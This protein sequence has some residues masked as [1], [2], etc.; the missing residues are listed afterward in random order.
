LPFSFP[1]ARRVRP[2]KVEAARSGSCLRDYHPF[3]SLTVTER[4]PSG[5]PELSLSI[6]LPSVREAFTPFPWICGFY[7]MILIFF[8]SPPRLH[9][10]PTLNLLSS[11]FVRT[12]F[13][14]KSIPYFTSLFCSL[15]PLKTFQE[16]G[17][18]PQAIF[19]VGWALIARLSILKRAVCWILRPHYSLFAGNLSGRTSHLTV[20]PAPT[21]DGWDSF[22]LLSL[23]C[24]FRRLDTPKHY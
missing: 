18:L 22:P 14:T 9:A 5:C 7:V 3:R 11:F 13:L 15:F 21:L 1:L 6:P 24:S 20:P 10:L 23:K 2:L 16:D 12:L 4:R 19:S 17:V 8:S